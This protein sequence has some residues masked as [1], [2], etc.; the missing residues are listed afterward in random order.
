V[1]RVGGLDVPTPY[2]SPLE[3]A[4]IPD[5]ARVVGQIKSSFGF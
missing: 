2:S 3:H 1:A 5:A 4:T